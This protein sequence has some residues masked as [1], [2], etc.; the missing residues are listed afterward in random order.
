MLLT[1]STCDLLPGYT[2]R[3]PSALL[4]SDRSRSAQAK[5]AEAALLPQELIQISR[6]ESVDW[7]A[8]G[9]GTS[10]I[11]STP[12]YKTCDGVM[13]CSPDSAIGRHQRF[14]CSTNTARCRVTNYG[15]GLLG[16]SR[17]QI[18]NLS[19]SQSTT[20]VTTRSHLNYTTRYHHQ[21][22]HQRRHFQRSVAWYFFGSV[23]VWLFYWMLTLMQFC[24]LPELEAA[25]TYPKQV[26]V[27]SAGR[28]PGH[29]AR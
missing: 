15:I 8:A 3:C 20:S 23:A 24:K 16:M 28:S 27:H 10:C 17:Y 13:P 2:A 22:R 4:H 19:A 25:H 21:H 7:A 14:K 29:A 1:E 11:Y 6:P 9:V 26:H 12:K 5:C 18:D